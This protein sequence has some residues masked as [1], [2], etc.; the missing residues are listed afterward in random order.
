MRANRYSFFLLIL[1]LAFG[2]TATAAASSDGS[3]GLN[4]SACHSFPDQTPP[5]PPAPTPDPTPPPAPA[6][7]PTPPPAPAPD[8]TPPPASAPDPTPPPASAPAP[9]PAAPA[10]APA[11]DVIMSSDAFYAIMQILQ[12]PSVGNPAP[13]DSSFSSTHRGCHLR[14]QIGDPPRPLFRIRG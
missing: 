6:P 9:A 11:T 3:K 14:S 10:P 4:C 2:I 8:P 7:D 13:S 12:L 1:L 5:P